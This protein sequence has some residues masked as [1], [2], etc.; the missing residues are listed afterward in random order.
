MNKRTMF[1]IY[2]VLFAVGGLFWWPLSHW[3]YPDWYHNFLGFDVLTTGEYA[4]AKTIGT[5]A[6]LPVLGMVLIARHPERNRDFFVGVL[7]LSLLMV[8]TYVY[9]IATGDFPSG[10]WLNV[11]LISMNVAVSC[12]LYPWRASAATARAAA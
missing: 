12:W 3:L 11:G 8:G 5:L 2:S 4:M 1:R 9:L 7:I 10:E 6:F